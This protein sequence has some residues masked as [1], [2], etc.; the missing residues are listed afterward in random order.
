MYFMGH[1]SAFSPST[2]RNLWRLMLRG[3]SILL[4]SG[5]LI[6]SIT[7]ADPPHLPD[8]YFN[9]YDEALADCAVK[10]QWYTANYGWPNGYQCEWNS[11]G[12]N[13]AKWAV[14]DFIFNGPTLTDLYRAIYP[15]TPC[16]AGQNYVAPGVCTIPPPE[17]T[18]NNG[19][20]ADA[21]RGDPCNAATGNEYYT[22]VDLTSVDGTVPIIR[23]YN[24]SL[25]IDV[26]FG[27]GWT[28]SIFG[29]RLYI[30]SNTVQLVRTDGRGEAFTCNGSTCQGDANT[31]IT[32]SQDANG[33]TLTTK[34][35]TVER[36]NTTGKVLTQTDRNGRTTSYGY[37]T[38]GRLSTVTGPFGHR[39]T[40]TYNSSS[41]GNHISQITGGAQSPSY[42]YDAKNNLIKASFYP[43]KGMTYQY[44]NSS[45]P[46]N[47][48]GVSYFSGSSNFRYATIAYDSAGKVV[49][50]QHA[51]GI[52]QTTF[53]YDSP[54]QTTVT[55]AANT[56]EVMTFTSNMG[57]KALVAKVNQG[58][59]KNVAQAFDVNNN[60]TCK[61][62]EEGRVTTYTY[63]GTNQKV[64][65][66]EG[67][68]G[69]C[70]APVTT[71][72][73]RTIMYSYLS[74]TLDLP[75]VIQSPSVYAG[76][77]KTTT[78][79]Y[80]DAAHPTLPTQITQ[81]GFTP[82]GAPVSRSVGLTYNS[83]GQVISIDGPR[84]DVND[85]TTLAYYDCATGGAC[86]QLRS[87][88]NALGQV[89]TFDTYDAYG[90]LTQMTDPNGLRTSYLYYIAYDYLARLI[91][92]TQTPPTGTARITQYS[93]NQAGGDLVSVSLPDGTKFIYS[94]NTARQL[95][96]VTDNGGN[97]IT[98]SH[99]GK[100]NR[101]SEYTYN[102]TNVMV[103]QLDLTY[104]IRNHVSSIN[105]AGSLTQ[106]INDAVGNLTQQIDPNNNPPTTNSFD[107]L[108][109][110]AQT[111]NSLSGTT[112]YAYD[113]NGRLQQ[114]V[115]PNNTTTQY[116]YDDLGNLLQE[117]S[118]DRGTTAYTYD[119][120]GN[121]TSI[122]DARGIMATYAYDALNRVTS[123]NYPGTTEDVTYTYD[124]GTG[125]TAGIG[126]LCQVVDASGTT[127]YSYN[128]FGNILT[129]SETEL[130]IVYTTSYTYDAA[131][132]IKT[133]TYPDNR[134]VTYT[135]DSLGRIT[136]VS[137][138]VS[139]VAKTLASAQTYRAD[140]LL[141]TQSYG[142][143][144][145]ETRTYD[146]QGRLTNQALGT[147]DTR[148][149]GYD[150][151][152]NVTSRQNLSQT[153]SYGYDALDRLIQ[154]SITSTPSSST[155]F[156]YDPNGNRQSDSGGS[157]IYLSATNRL[158]QYYSQPITLDTAGNTV[159]DGIYTYVYN[160]AGELQ[161][162]AQGGTLGSYVYNH[163]HQRTQKTTASSTTVYHYDVLGNLILE[164]NASG[165]SQVAY[166]WADS[167]PLAQIVKSGSTDTLSYLLADQEGTPR[168]ATSTT[169]AV[170]WR[171]EGRAFG[172]TAPSGSVT[173]NLRY[174]G[175]YFDSE[176]GLYYW[177]AR[178]YDPKTGRGISSDP[179]GLAGGLNT[180]TYVSNNPLRWIDPSGL[181][182][183]DPA[184]PDYFGNGFGG[185]GGGGSLALG[186]SGSAARSALSATEVRAALPDAHI[187]TRA[188][189]EALR[190]AGVSRLRRLDFINS[191]Q[192]GTIKACKAT[193]DES[194]LRF[195]GGTSGQSGHYLTPSFPSTGGVREMLA[196]PPGNAATSFTQFRLAPGTQ[197]FQGIA[198]PNFGQPGGGVQIFVQNPILLSQ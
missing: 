20:S 188:L 105:A 138:T 34:D 9:T 144:L 67:L 48:T 56:Q 30:H 44:E 142:N 145:N 95:S 87:L 172:N 155:S 194:F 183:I 73:T 22:E 28:S 175:Q 123:I 99:D 120:A 125:C 111:L 170:V 75:T 36:F 57:T 114:V 93:Y 85:V 25:M 38:S 178:Y 154:D 11:Y 86:G 40:L 115:A 60:L 45:F 103:R 137:A 61:K 66:T 94:Y 78:M 21:M 118:A 17:A 98:Y 117:T 7:L 192:E 27:A 156:S 70:D 107:A 41:N 185:F 186:G 19:C 116:Q 69:T 198:A 106:Q 153:A 15:V 131:D 141:L 71:S 160:N 195:Y 109:R 79:T 189:S 81:S 163:R 152:G 3:L 140:G 149:Y 37:D 97:Y 182:N 177:G 5:L 4:L 47:L 51:A 139:G 190:E 1:L 101:I 13:T 191:F 72:A 54:T 23:Y 59:G 104:D 128:V 62:D 39:L 173:V 77:T 52:E 127:Q 6:P 63:N 148:I 159:N 180:Y 90:K 50:T 31:H 112:S 124:S 80:G 132:R 42:T 168:L 14:W 88:T 12:T 181:V 179:I 129:Q 158:S 49:S 193:G 84:T 167:Q 46:N 197:Y 171:Y 136:S 91:T 53:S 96:R 26:G 150:A 102:P 122:S 64:S 10:Q 35:G 151:N 164:T 126:R 196:L 135:R 8:E 166:V 110:L 176:T 100:G 134:L 147:A 133:I 89:T 16:P 121:V 83:A 146:L 68:V 108:N 76:H 174:P 187:G 92:T 169:K 74:P 82:A 157:Y 2:P 43:T 161:S 55:D 29:N 113:P 58:D 33:Y 119:N 65:M 18:K 24:S 130:G 143:G 165:V 162:V 184:E 32:L